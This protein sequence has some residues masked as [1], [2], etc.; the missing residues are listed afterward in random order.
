MKRVGLY[1]LYGIG[2]LLAGA[3]F[4]FKVLQPVQV[5]PRI[6]LAPGFALVDQDGRTLTSE[7][8]R[9]AVVL[10]SFYYTA[11][12]QDCQQMLPTLQAIQAGLREIA[13]STPVRMVTIS[14]DPAHDTPERLRD[15]AAQVGADPDLWRFA[16]QPD[17]TLLKAII[18]GGFEVYYRPRA[19]GTFD[20]DPAFILVDPLGVVRGE[21]RYRTLTP[22]QER[23]LR[24]INVLL[25]EIRNAKGAAKGLYEA[26]HLFLCYPP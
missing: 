6:R 23:I 11:C 2:V 19:D 15:F 20:F 21:Y 12:R 22:D 17:T 9:G 13:S 8:M 16:T 7:D 5:L 1:L 24:H 26:A 3:V 10:Y 14:F 18:G 4:L 25:D